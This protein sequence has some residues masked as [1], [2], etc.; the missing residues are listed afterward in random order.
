MKIEDDNNPKSPK[1]VGKRIRYIRDELLGLSRSKFAEK[2]K[3]KKITKD[4]LQNW[5]EARFK[6]LKVHHVD[7]LAQAF[8]EE[9]VICNRDWLL[10]GTGDPPRL[11]SYL[12]QFMEET[13]RPIILPVQLKS[14]EEAIAAEL[15]AFRE[16]HV[17]AVDAIVSDNALAPCYLPGDYVAG[18]RYIGTDIEKAIGL[19][20]I[21]QT[22]TGQV[23]TRKVEAGSID[24]HF[25]LLSFKQ[26]TTSENYTMSNVKLFSAAPIIWIRK[27]LSS[28]KR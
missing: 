16:C 28:F 26:T 4:A 1:A 13:T 3:N 6:G 7:L 10:D 5:E 17:D 22:Q 8:E 20:C 9:G 24:G 14:D 21:V 12:D 25:N 27:P 15:R 19:P 23:V 2:H 11:R 18:I